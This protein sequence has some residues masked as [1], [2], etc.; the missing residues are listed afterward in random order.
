MEPRNFDDV[1]FSATLTPHR[2][3]GRRGFLVLMAAIAGLWFLTGAF[4]WSLG[5]WP[6]IG[7]FG[8][9]F[10]AVWLAFKLNYRAARAYE[11]VAVS[12]TELVIRKVKPSGR[13]QEFRFNPAWV[14]LEVADEGVKRVT[15]RSRDRRVTVAAFLN[16]EDRKSFARAFTAALATARN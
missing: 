8:L 5:A 9:D 12:R 15:V 10:L 14:R 3:L 4:F 6:V 11:E 1:I 16:P 7:F 2:S 13:A